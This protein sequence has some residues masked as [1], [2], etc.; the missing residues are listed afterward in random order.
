[1]NKK[2]TILRESTMLCSNAHKVCLFE[3]QQI[4]GKLCSFSFVWKILVRSFFLSVYENISSPA[5]K[6]TWFDASFYKQNEIKW[7]KRK[8][9]L[10]I[11]MGLCKIV[12]L[13]LGVCNIQCLMLWNKMKVFSL[14]KRWE[15]T[16][17]WW[18]HQP[19]SQRV[20]SCD[21]IASFML[22]T[23]TIAYFPIFFLLAL[24]CVIS[25][26]HCFLSLSLSLTFRRSST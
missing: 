4:H 16:F 20:L 14:K 9:R 25:N 11:E 23:T 24:V 5:S 22:L 17:R 6:Q 3:S 1:M 10:N 26:A 13:E 21:S 12:N 8:M 15:E 19:A 18:V 2:Q 7:T